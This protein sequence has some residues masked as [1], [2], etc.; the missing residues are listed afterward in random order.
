MFQ[1][2]Y[3]ITTTRLL[4]RP[5]TADDLPGLHDIYSRPDVVRYLY[6]EPHTIDQ[7]R[8]LLAA[9]Y[10]STRLAAQGDTLR[11]AVLRRDTGR[12]I[13][14]VM[15]RW[16]SAEHQQGE[17]GFVFHPD[18]HGMGFAAEASRELLRIAF[19][20]LGLHRVVG[21]CDARNTAS[22]GLLERLGMRREALLVENEFVKGEWCD[23]L[24]LAILARE[25]GSAREA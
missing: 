4:L 14:E 24:N 2:E 19:A 5:F 10:D 20:E 17:I 23:E 7:T 21:R 18:H 11:C 3:P 12:L 8:E 6:T 16:V 15:L 22:S 1:P 9:W 25:W 13:G